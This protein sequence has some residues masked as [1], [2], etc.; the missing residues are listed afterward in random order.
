MKNNVDPHGELKSLITHKEGLCA[1]VILPMHA[2]AAE[3]P[4]DSLEIEH[5]IEKVKM[6]FGEMNKPDSQILAKINAL[7][8]E[9]KKIKSGKG[10]GIFAS[11]DVSQL[12][13]FPFEVKEKVAVSDSFEIRDLV[14]KERYD[15][16]YY[17]LLLTR[18]N[19]RLFK[20]FEGKLTE[21]SDLN[22]PATFDGVD[23]EIPAHELQPVNSDQDL[24]RDRSVTANSAE[25]FYNIMD[26]KLNTYLKIETPF[27]IAGPE[28]EVA[29][30]LNHS[31][32]K[33]QI[34]EKI[35]GSFNGH[36][37]SKLE[38]RVWRAIQVYLKKEERELL[39]RLRDA[40]REF[41]SSGL[42]DV[43]YD[44]KQGKGQILLVERD[45]QIEAYLG[46]DEFNLQLTPDSQVK[47][48]VTDAVDD[49]I[50]T[51]LQKNGKVVFVGNGL[52]KDYNGIAMINRY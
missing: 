29:M 52:L 26:K 16:E 4:I 12:T 10:V 24:E 30:F 8:E 20:G 23:Y 51:M 47:H 50:E 38:T 9:A 37:L 39:H 27:I 11:H 46:E 49:V 6:L 5:A 34:K 44:A 22:F 7:K 32:H 48:K 25:E 19:F 28:K 45:L 3:K 42:R 17:A 13:I 33:N 2:S 41:I 15:I 21:I 18:T 43:W 35:I 1:S 14:E 31:T 36:T 40:G